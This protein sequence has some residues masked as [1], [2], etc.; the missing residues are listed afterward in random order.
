MEWQLSKQKYSHNNK[1]TQF[2]NKITVDKMT[3]VSSFFF[4][5]KSDIFIQT[6]LS[7]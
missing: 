3:K 2:R 1:I 5:I 4:Y 7:L 6:F